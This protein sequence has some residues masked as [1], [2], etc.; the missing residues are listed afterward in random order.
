MTWHINAAFLILNIVVIVT[1][2]AIVKPI[3]DSSNVSSGGHQI[4]RRNP[5]PL[6]T[7]S[8]VPV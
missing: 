7:F 5:T 2:S 8:R 6:A 3:P 1:I 4:D